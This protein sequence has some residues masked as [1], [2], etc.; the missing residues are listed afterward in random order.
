[1]WI[2]H[3]RSTIVF[4]LILTADAEWWLYKKHPSLKLFLFRYQIIYFSFIYDVYKYFN[5]GWINRSS[6][7]CDIQYMI[8]IYWIKVYAQLWILCVNNHRIPSYFFI[9]IQSGVLIVFGSIC[10]INIESL[11]IHLSFNC[12]VKFF[13]ICQ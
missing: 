1:M 5:S 9:I 8:F 11:I 3:C 7:Y 12:E 4:I 10:Y 13:S 2:C 6:Q